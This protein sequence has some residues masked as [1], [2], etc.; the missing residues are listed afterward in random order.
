[1]KRKMR[2]VL[3]ATLLVL[4]IASIV[5]ASVYQCT[6]AYD[7]FGAIIMKNLFIPHWSAWFFLV[8]IVL[9]SIG[10]LFIQTEG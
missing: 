10:W 3:W 6:L 5:F 2:L 4:G 1:M 8:G 9:T 7:K